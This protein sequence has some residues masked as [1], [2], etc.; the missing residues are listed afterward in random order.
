[1]W[2]IVYNDLQ[3]KYL[4]VNHTDQSFNNSLFK[5]ILQKLFDMNELYIGGGICTGGIPVYSRV[6]NLIGAS[7]DNLTENVYYYN[8][9]GILEKACKNIFYK[10]EF[11]KNPNKYVDIQVCAMEK[12]NRIN[13]SNIELMLLFSS[14]SI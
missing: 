11:A 4:E 9:I 8:K 12:E 10:K 6:S 13:D 5:Q 2:K 3:Q 14:L 7:R 1:M